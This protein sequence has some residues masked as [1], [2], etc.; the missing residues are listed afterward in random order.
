MSVRVDKEELPRLE[1]LA[2]R[3]SWFF[4]DRITG[5]GPSRMIRVL[6]DVPAFAA[7]EGQLQPEVRP[8]PW[9]TRIMLSRGMAIQP[10][11]QLESVEGYVP[12]GGHITG[13][14]RRLLRS[15]ADAAPPGLVCYA[16]SWDSGRTLCWVATQTARLLTGEVLSLEAAPMSRAGRDFQAGA[17]ASGQLPTRVI[18]IPGPELL[19]LHALPAAA[20]GL[21]IEFGEQE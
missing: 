6:L 8:G 3:F 9:P 18:A 4:V 15:P 10:L 21:D 1:Q 19:Y 12:F 20:N 16:S 14:G 7:C 13:F 17:L 2:E 5:D 11:V